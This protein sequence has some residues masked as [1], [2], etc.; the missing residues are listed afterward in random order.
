MKRHIKTLKKKLKSFNPKIKEECGVFG[1]SN[2][3]DAS[4]LTALGLHALQHR[5]QEGCGIVTFDGNHYFS[6]K[7]FGLVGDNFNKE[8]ILK[9][10]KGNYAIGHNRYSTT[11]ENTLRNIQP[12]FA[13][14]N[15]GGIGVAHNGNLTNSISL[16]NKL[17]EEGA[18]FYT[19]SDTET[20]VQLIAKS[21]R[22]KTIDKIIDAI[23]QIQGGY[24]LVMLTQNSLIG[25]RDPNGIRPLIIGKL[26]N[27]YV[28]ASETCALDII[29]AKFI[30]EVENGEIVV[31]ENGKIISVKPFPPRKIRPC[32][33]EY[34]YFSRPDSILNG[35]SAY[36]HRKNLG[37]ELAKENNL[38]A[39]IVVPVPDSGNAAALGFAHYLGMKFELGLIRNHYVGR[40]F[41]EPSQKIRSLGVKLKLNANQST[42]KGKKIILIDDSLVRGTTSHKIIKMLYDAGA[43]EVH[44][45]I[46]CPEIR[47][48][49]FYG[50]DTPTKKELLA[51]NKT[52]DEICEYIGAKSLNFLTLNGLYKAIGF[53][54]RNDNYPQL[55]DHYF[56]GDYPVKPVD[57][58]GDNKVTQLSLLNTG[59]NN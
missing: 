49:D 2:T 43:K 40:T 10:L 48:P 29:G 38:K 20:I 42:I 33:F 11:G 59:Y 47:F 31:I 34:I 26:N 6:E 17:V 1:I 8:K 35:K 55:T 13:D 9:K 7:R 15:A 36:E 5:G 23:F 44:M 50:V 58:L 27:S 41:I 57:E 18:I 24:A 3:K 19:T 12:F 28:L 56:T 32:V 54:K 14:T 52:N 16:R 39:D 51:A 4:A 30:R 46:A 22:K 53:E 37:I 25:V 45:K 21:K